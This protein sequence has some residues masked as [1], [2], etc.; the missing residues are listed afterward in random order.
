MHLA[1][2]SGKI[3]QLSGGLWSPDGVSCAQNGGSTVFSQIYFSSTAT[4]GSA[5]TLVDTTVNF[6]ATNGLVGSDMAIFGSVGQGG[7]IV[8]ANTAT[9]VTFATL[10]GGKTVHTGDTYEIIG[11][12]TGNSGQYSYV[13]PIGTKYGVQMNNFGPMNYTQW[14]NDNTCW[15]VNGFTQLTEQGTINCY[16]EWWRGWCGNE[17][18]M[19]AFGASS[20]GGGSDTSWTVSSGMGV[21]LSSLTN[22]KV[23]WGSVTSLV[24]V[25]SRVD[26]L[27]DVYFHP[28]NTPPATSFPPYSDLSIFTWLI[29]NGF[30]ESTITSGN[31]AP[32]TISGV[33]YMVTVDN[34]AGSGFINGGRYIQMFTRPTSVLD[35]LGTNSMWGQLHV[36]HDLGAILAFWQQSNPKDDNNN[37]IK[38]YSGTTITSAV[39]PSTLYLNA[40]NNGYE[41][42][43][44]SSSSDYITSTQG[45]V[46][47]QGESNGPT[48]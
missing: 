38:N 37:P 47:M 24:P 33:Q 14:I 2:A 8:T 39:L 25:T 42:D 34:P 6:G 17:T 45:W 20:G 29:D 31:G 15:G 27:T 13:G 11:P 18:I 21:Q 44:V 43:F 30:Y 26:A 5:T 46:A 28:T 22:C 23:A 40:I 41:V 35:G 16:P 19:A 48:P 4:S 9:S 12:S 1:V 36:I 10:S 32:V 3:I 7:I